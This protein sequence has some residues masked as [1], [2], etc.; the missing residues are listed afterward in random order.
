MIS[1]IL[2]TSTMCEVW[3][4][5]RN[6]R[7]IQTRTGELNGGGH[8]KARES[9]EKKRPYFE[10]PTIFIGNEVGCHNPVIT[11]RTSMDNPHELS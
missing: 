7:E 10:I 11:Y 1:L 3:F 8:Q 9:E 2:P 5:Y 4:R 6:H